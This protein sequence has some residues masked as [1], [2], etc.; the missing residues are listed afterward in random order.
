MKWSSFINLAFADIYVSHPRGS[1]NRLAGNGRARKNP[2]RLFD[3]QN[4]NRGGVNK[5]LEQLVFYRGQ[6]LEISYTQQHS[7]NS[8]NANCDTGTEFIFFNEL[9]SATCRQKQAKRQVFPEQ[10]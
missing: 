1:N 9:N 3:S 8:G 2:N 7:C 4:N 5:G 10:S 6:T